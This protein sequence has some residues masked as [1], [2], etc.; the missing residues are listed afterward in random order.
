MT[1]MHVM[2]AV[3]RNQVMGC[4]ATM[5]S[6]L[7]NTARAAD[8]HFH[9]FT[10]ELKD[11]EIAV[12]ER[13]VTDAGGQITA[14]PYDPRRIRQLQTSRLISHTTYA[15]LEAG[16]L[17]PPDVTRCVYVDCDIV[18]EP[19]IRELWETDLAGRTVGAILNGSAEDSKN[20]Q[21]RLG[22]REP[23]YFN[24]GVLLIDLARWRAQ[25]VFERALAAALEVGPRLILH[26][27]D[28]LN[29][30][31]QSDWTPLPWR[32]N[33]WVID[34]ELREDT[35]AVFHYMGAPKPW[36]VDYDRPFGDRFFKYLDRTP[37]RGWRPW[38]PA[39]VGLFVRRLR[40]RIPYLPGAVRMLRASFQREPKGPGIETDGPTATARI[41]SP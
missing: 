29:L 40:R 18:F 11:A 19:D 5:R 41:S 12:L 30:A 33:V 1:R 10:T 16:E 4:A 24:S 39:G 2:L 7:H 17:L 23:R 27:Q 26:D 32:W 25:R 35:D 13:T 6:I 37:F 15:K 22:L 14:R 8:L 9:L 36:D 31:L 21:R 34:P 28:A 3:D 20:N 38:N